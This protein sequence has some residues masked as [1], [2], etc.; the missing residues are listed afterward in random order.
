MLA[1]KELMLSPGGIRLEPLAAADD[2]DEEDEEDEEAG[3]EVADEDVAAGEDAAGGEGGEDVAGLDRTKGSVA[4]T[5]AVIAH[6]KAIT[7]RR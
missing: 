4:A 5:A 7:G 3:V 2:E 1:L 6:A